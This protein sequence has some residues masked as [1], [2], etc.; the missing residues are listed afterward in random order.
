MGSLGFP[1][2]GLAQLRSCLPH[3]RTGLRCNRLGH[4]FRIKLRHSFCELFLKDVGSIWE[5][6]FGDVLCVLQHLLEH[7]FC[8]DFHSNWKWN[9][10]S[11]SMMRD[12]FRSRTQLVKPSKTIIFTLNIH[13]FTHKKNMILND[14]HD[15]SLPV[16]AL[17]FNFTFGI[18]C[19]SI[20]DF[21]GSK[22]HMFLVIV[23]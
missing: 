18:D 20:L 22:I 1:G 11:F 15:L 6:I 7:L 8:I 4:F 2:K 3:G 17:I 23:F 9:F 13:V 10:T 14:V 5:F 12:I 16:W 19:A 21:F